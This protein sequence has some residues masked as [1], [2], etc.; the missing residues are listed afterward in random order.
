MP[1]APFRSREIIANLF[2][3]LMVQ[4]I[5]YIIDNNKEVI[6]FTKESNS[7]NHYGEKI[8]TDDF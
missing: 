3:G 2:I 8:N 7:L 6:Q 4:M 5:Y 1:Q